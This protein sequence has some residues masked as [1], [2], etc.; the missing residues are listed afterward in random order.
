MSNPA[1]SYPNRAAALR[2]RLLGQTVQPIREVEIEGEKFYIRTALVIDRQKITDIAGMTV[3]AGKGGVEVGSVSMAAMTVAALIVLAVDEVGNPLCTP[4]DL[5]A[6]MNTPAGGWVQHLG[7]LCLAAA[8]GKRDLG[9][10]S[11]E[12]KKAVDSSSSSPTGSSE[13]SQS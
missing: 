10:G 6:L 9:E 3:T 1:P 13:P 12:A 11:G 7:E 2:A 5:E 8:N 4:V